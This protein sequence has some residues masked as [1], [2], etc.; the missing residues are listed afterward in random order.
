MEA[1]KSGTDV[2]PGETLYTIQEDS[3]VRLGN[4]V[5]QDKDTIVATK[6]GILNVAKKKNVLNIWVENSQ[7]RYIPQQEDLVIGVVTERL[8]DSYKIDIGAPHAATLSV[9][10]F[11]GATRKNRPFL[12][13]GSSVYARVAVANK[14]METELVCTSAANKGDG[15]GEL[16]GGYLF[17]CSLGL[18]RG[19]L[20]ET[21]PV[22]N[23]LGK[24]IP[25]EIAVGMN[26]R[27]WIYS[28]SVTN[29]ILISNAIL[30]AEHLPTRHV[31][32]MVQQL[33]Q[34]AEK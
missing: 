23:A 9:L 34:R 18:A 25:Y 19:L 33:L 26:G 28:Q 12:T 5:V 22:L 24:R 10:A 21:N 8:G 11:E 2:M 4:G 27:V 7:K 1:P 30:N 15:F 3:S 6:A 17:K 13:V 29:T 14:D 31:E 20:Y 32:S 16:V